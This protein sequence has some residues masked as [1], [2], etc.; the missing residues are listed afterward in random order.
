MCGGVGGQR[1]AQAGGQRKRWSAGGEGW[2]HISCLRLELL[3]LGPSPNH[4][5]NPNYNPN[6]DPNAVPNANPSQGALTPTLARAHIS[7]HLLESELILGELLELG[8]V[9]LGRGWVGVG[10]G[11][12]VAVG[13]LGLGLRFGLALRLG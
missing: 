12:G 7:R 11:A 1:G 6:S 5:P 3:A 8:G 13:V 10:A 9:G 4:N 2:A